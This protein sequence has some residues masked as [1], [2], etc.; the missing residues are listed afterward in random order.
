MVDLL[1]QNFA[2]TKEQL[3]H[4]NG[5]RLLGEHGIVA[6]TLGDYSTACEM[7]QGQR[8][9]MKSSCFGIKPR[10]GAFGLW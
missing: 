8:T 4:M 7:A 10:R 1:P 6:M 5:L 2:M 9:F 3:L